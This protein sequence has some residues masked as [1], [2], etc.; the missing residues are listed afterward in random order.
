M[1]KILL[2]VLLSAT[3]LSA[4]NAAGTQ[5]TTTT[6]YHSETNYKW[7][8]FAADVTG[9]YV[10]GAAGVS[11]PTDKYDDNGAYAVSVGWQFHPLVRAEIEGGYRH[12][13]ADSRVQGQGNIYSVLLNG[14][15][16]IKNDTRFTPY[17]GA[18]AGW[19]YENQNAVGRTN[20]NNGSAFAYQGI[21]GVSYAIDGNWALTAQ[22]NYI[23]TTNFDFSAHEVKGGVRYT[24]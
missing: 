5:T 24:F 1:K 21:A 10:A 22:Y 6:H 18:G 8:P 4:A 12:L 14:Y 17:L 7:N 20:D 3:A 19:A 2:A 13:N 16:D 15:W 9:L 11:M 23:D